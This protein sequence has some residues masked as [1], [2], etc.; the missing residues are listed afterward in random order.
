MTGK[1]LVIQSKIYRNE[2]FCIVL[3]GIDKFNGII[4]HLYICTISLRSHYSC[5]G[6][7]RLMLLKV[8]KVRHPNYFRPLGLPHISSARVA[9]FGESGGKLCSVNDSVNRF[10]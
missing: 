9:L 1:K 3:C 8:M 2:D 6:A 5:I 10:L 4:H 7:K